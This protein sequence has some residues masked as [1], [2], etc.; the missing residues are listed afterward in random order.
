MKSLKAVPQI[1][2]LKNS[3]RLFWTLTTERAQHRILLQCICSAMSA[4]NTYIEVELDVGYSF[5]RYDKD[6]LILTL[7]FNLS[8]HLCQKPNI[9]YMT[10][11]TWAILSEKTSLTQE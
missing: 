3:K 7:G 4:V 1:V 8:V 6:I 10:K 2:A 9:E 11:N 5:A